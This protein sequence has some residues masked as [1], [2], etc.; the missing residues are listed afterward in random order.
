MNY[1]G[2][3]KEYDF[4]EFAGKV[5]PR[6][7]LTYEIYDE[8]NIVEEYGKIETDDE[9][10]VI[11]L[12]SKPVKLSIKTDRDINNFLNKYPMS[13]RMYYNTYTYRKIYN[14]PIANTISPNVIDDFYLNILDW[15]STGLLAVATTT[16]ISLLKPDLQNSNYESIKDIPVVANLNKNKPKA[17]TRFDDEVNSNFPGYTSCKFYKEVCDH[18]LQSCA[19]KPL[20]ASGGNDNKVFIWELGYNIPILRLNEHTA[21]VKA[22]TWSPLSYP[23]LATGGGTNDRTIRIWDTVHRTAI[24]NC[25]TQSQICNLHWSKKSLE[26]ISSHGYTLNQLNVWDF[27]VSGASKNNLRLRKLETMIG[28]RCRALFMSSSKDG[29][30][31]ASGS[32]D[33]NI[34]IWSPFYEG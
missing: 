19:Y 1:N 6:R 23:L 13:S 25:E 18:S 20:L 27:T 26:L 31:I 30:Y 2:N 16:G 3:L 11:H 17:G 14:K 28:H 34:L 12:N 21:A 29:N 8:N 33:G 9:N 5:A 15:S 7:K 32:G 22:L 24:T 10:D 4:S